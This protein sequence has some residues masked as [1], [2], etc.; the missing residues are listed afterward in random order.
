MKGSKAH[1]LQYSILTDPHMY[2]YLQS[3]PKVKELLKSCL[4]RL[5]GNHLVEKETKI[6]FKLEE[7]VVEKVRH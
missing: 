1:S 5:E 6:T 3:P 4:F 2:Y 7:Y